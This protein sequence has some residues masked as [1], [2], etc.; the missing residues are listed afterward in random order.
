MRTSSGKP[1]NRRKDPAAARLAA[2]RSRKLSPARRSEIARLAARARWAR[3]KPAAFAPGVPA[4][5]EIA[6]ELTRDIPPAA[7]GSLPRDL[8]DRLDH[9]IYGTPTR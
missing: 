9:Y 8:C 2:M 1:A 5:W 6:D 4:I 3:R 7:W